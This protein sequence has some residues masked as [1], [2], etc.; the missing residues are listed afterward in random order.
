[1]L[2]LFSEKKKVLTNT[3]NNMV[4]KVVQTGED[5]ESDKKD[6]MHG[7]EMRVPPKMVRADSKLFEPMQHFD[8]SRSP[9]ELKKSA[10]YSGEGGGTPNK[11]KAGAYNYSKED[12]GTMFIRRRIRERRLSL[13]FADDLLS[14]EA[15]VNFFRREIFGMAFKELSHRTKKL[16]KTHYDEL[17]A[18]RS[19][20]REILQNKGDLRKNFKKGM[21]KVKGFG[22]WDLLWNYKAE[23]IKRESPYNE[24]PSY[25]LRQVIVKGGDDL[26]Q[27]IV[28]MQLIKKLQSV[29][30]KEGASLVLLTYE[31]VV[32]NSSSGI[33]GT[34]CII[35]R[36]HS[37]QHLYRRSK[38][39]VP[40]S[41]TA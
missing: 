36:V 6:T 33:I 24:F 16:L 5:M 21:S 29:F 38:E 32:I 1:M 19:K 22:P 17:I 35:F 9:A 25:K 20:Y 7:G 15:K 10:I 2:G 37:R 11:R 28:A 31:I 8:I 12:H 3:L 4:R 39:E 14:T 41:F 34:L 40:R 30:Q 23:V 26:R 13:H 18:K 27:E